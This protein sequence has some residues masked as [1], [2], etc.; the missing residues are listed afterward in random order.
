MFGVKSKIAS[1]YHPSSIYDIAKTLHLV[2][3]I[4]GFFPL[5]I[6]ET[7]TGTKPVICKFGVFFTIL[8]LLLYLSSVIHFVFWSNVKLFSLSYG[9]KVGHYGCIAI[10]VLEG[11]TTIILFLSVFPLMKFQNFVFKNVNNLESVCHQLKIDNTSLL[12][13]S[14]CLIGFYIAFV[15]IFYLLG[16]GIFIHTQFVSLNEVPPI[17]LIIIGL[18]PRYYLLSYVT[19]FAIYVLS[20]HVCNSEFYKFMELYLNDTM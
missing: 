11:I 3:K 15:T 20:M 1:H 4:S 14:R 2:M 6:E 9:G 7:K 8:H 19:F 5:K 18:L 16:A 13:K 17:D 10:L 12:F